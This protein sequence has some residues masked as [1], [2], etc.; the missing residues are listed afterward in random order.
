LHFCPK[1]CILFQTFAMK[2]QNAAYTTVILVL[3]LFSLTQCKKSDPPEEVLYTVI[4]SPEALP[5]VQQPIGKYR[6]YRDSATSMLDSVVVT[7]SALEM[8]VVPKTT[9]TW[10]VQP[11]F[12]SQ[13]YSIILTKK[14]GSPDS[15]WFKGNAVTTLDY[16]PPIL[17]TVPLRLWE[18]G[19]INND[20]Y[21][22][23][24]A[25]I[26]PPVSSLT[27][28]VEGIT[29]NDVY[30]YIDEPGVDINHPGYI[31]R[32][33]YWARG[34]GLIQRTTI[35]SGGAIKTYYLVRHN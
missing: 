4:I 11:A 6:V 14:N 12:N 21:Y 30:A 34:I 17:D 18:S 28:T 26:I 7:Q 24:V 2:K 3:I 22:H 25:H 35:Y 10:A 15:I 29:Y 33:Y 27:K 13:T 5:Y 31:K 8:H 1:H 23:V 9:G 20:S 32:I 19:Y 16:P